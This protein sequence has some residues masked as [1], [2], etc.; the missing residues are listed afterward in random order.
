VRQNNSRSDHLRAELCDVGGNHPTW[1]SSGPAWGYS[2][3][4]RDYTYFSFD[5]PVTRD[6]ARADRTGFV[7][8][9]PESFILDE[10]QR[11]PELFEAIKISV[12][13]QR[14]PGRFL[15]TGSTNVFLVLQL[16]GSLAGRIQMCPCIL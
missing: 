10:V 12:D 1:S 5:D 11:I 16:S 3:E 7:A 15:L 8:D 13:R 2:Q 6:G 14:T 4:D 9:L